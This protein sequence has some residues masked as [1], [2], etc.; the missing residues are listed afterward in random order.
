M[1]S[2]AAAAD[3]DIKQFDVKTAFLYGELDEDVYMAQPAG[4]DDGSGRVCKMKKSLYGL[5]QSSK[6]WNARFCSFLTSKG[7][8]A[9]PGDGCVYTRNGKKNKLIVV[10]YV[11]DGLVCGTST[12]EVDHFLVRLKKE[13]EVTI[14]DPDHYVGMEIARDRSKREIRISQKGYIEHVMLPKFGL[15]NAKSVITPMDPSVKLVD[16]ESKSAS[17]CP[18]RQA[19]GCLNYLAVVS[20]PD[21]SF[22]CMHLQFLYCLTAHPNSIS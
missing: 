16:V 18:Y 19:I 8:K 5:K 11:D 15:V 9:S 13:F 20:R 17:N 22:A 12:R 14:G 3:M 1:L 2:L 4:F 21:I 10:L 6:N 7:L